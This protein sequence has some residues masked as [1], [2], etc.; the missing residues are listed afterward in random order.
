[1][2]QGRRERQVAGGAAA[3]QDEVDRIV[4][5]WATERPDLDLAPLEV[6]SRVSRLARHLEIARRHAFTATGLE[7]WEFDVLSS[8]RRAGDPYELTPG[9]LIEETLVSSG[10]MTNRID[11]LSA[12]GLVTRAAD[13]DDRRVV[14]VRLTAQGQDLVDGAMARLLEIE[15]QHLGSLTPSGRSGVAS[16][17]RELLLGFEQ[18]TPSP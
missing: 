4:A 15:R 14:R 11:R 9:R 17:L 3:H 13:P 5:A 12:K 8:L 18:T 1:M 7:G 6:F 2:E 10:T 16:Q